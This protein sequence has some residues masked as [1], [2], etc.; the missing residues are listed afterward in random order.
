MN[1]LD[2][3]HIFSSNIEQTVRWYVAMLGAEV[4]YDTELVGHRNV[5]LEIGG[6]AL[7]VYE[8]PPRGPGRQIVHHLGIRTDDLRGLVAHMQAQ[9]HRFHKAITEEPAFRYVMCEAPDGLLLE[10]YEV[11]PGGE[12][13]IAKPPAPPAHKP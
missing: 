7:H 5:R 8:Q 9:G 3:A 6:G 1:R 4:I 11:K 2:H 12:W 13:M 10:M